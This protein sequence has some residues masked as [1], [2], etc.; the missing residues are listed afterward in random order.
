MVFGDGQCLL[1][2]RHPLLRNHQ[3]YIA[4]TMVRQ[5]SLVHDYFQPVNTR[6]GTL[7][8]RPALIV[9]CFNV[10]ALPFSSFSKWIWQTVNCIWR[11][12][13]KVGVATLLI[14]TIRVGFLLSTSRIRTTFRAHSPAEKLSN[15]TNF[16]LECDTNI[17]W[18]ILPSPLNSGW[19]WYFLPK[20]PF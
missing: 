2:I 8:N 5:R 16:K 19:Y 7:S 15:Q 13:K 11:H 12:E 14:F 6:K 17:S 3:C 4:S 10:V 20:Q 18:G 9:V 1:G